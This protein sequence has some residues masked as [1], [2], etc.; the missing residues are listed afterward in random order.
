MTAL[1]VPSPRSP[2]SLDDSQRVEQRL[3]LAVVTEL[4]RLARRIPPRPRA[5]LAMPSSVS[6]HGLG[7]A[8]RSASDTR[9]R[10]LA[11]LSAFEVSLEVVGHLP[12]QLRA[13]VRH[14]VAATRQSIAQPLR[15][16]AEAHRERVE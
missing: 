14:R 15:D 5:P 9:R 8:R 4:P 12:Q 11:A 2:R 10:C 16:A 6:G 3:R 1:P 7:V 13:V